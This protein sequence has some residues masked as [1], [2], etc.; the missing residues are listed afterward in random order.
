M[1][2]THVRLLVT[3][4]SGCYRFYRDDL[5]LATKWDDNGAY[6]EF[7]VGE[8]VWLA[9]FPRAEMAE[10]LGTNG[11]PAD[12]EAQDRIA[13][14]LAVDDVDASVAALREKGVA[15]A[16][17]PH[18]RKDWGLRVAHVRDPDGNLV[19]LFHDIEWERG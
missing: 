3:D 2:L 5:G 10:D 8:D 4:F 15:L 14:V 19:E 17:E 1:R 11:L 16:S 13:L 18:D 12:A 6:A 7:A 9:I